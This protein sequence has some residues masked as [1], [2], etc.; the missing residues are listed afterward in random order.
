MLRFEAVV[1]GRKTFGPLNR[2]LVIAEDK[3]EA[4]EFAKKVYQSR[5]IEV[6][7]L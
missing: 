2:V 1:E 7:E 5:F 6:K 4:E 3:I